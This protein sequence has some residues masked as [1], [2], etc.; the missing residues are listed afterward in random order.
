[1]S[2]YLRAILMSRSL[3][4]LASAIRAEERDKLVGFHMEVEAAYGLNR[5][6]LDCGTPAQ[7]SGKAQVR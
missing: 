5:F 7:F 6:S 2:P 1:M 3:A 4:G